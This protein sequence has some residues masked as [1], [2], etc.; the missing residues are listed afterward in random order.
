MIVPKIWCI[1]MCLILVACGGG[2]GSGNDPSKNASFNYVFR[3]INQNTTQFNVITN[4]GVADL[5]GDGLDDVVI[6]GGGNSDGINFITILIQTSEGTLTDRT[7]DLL[8]NNRISGTGH[9]LIADFDRDGY[10]DIWL[11][12][13]DDY[14]AAAASDMFWGSV[15][16]K[17]TRQHVDSG[18]ASHGACLADLN[19]DGYPDMLVY[20]TY[21]QNSWNAGY[22]INNGNRTFSQMISN[23]FVNGASACAVIKDSTTT[24]LAVLQSG[25][26]QMPGYASSINIMDSNLNLIKQIGIPQT[27]TSLAGM[28]TAIPID[29]NSDGLVD[30][31]LAWESWT[32]GGPGR[33]DVWLNQ[34]NDNFA[35]SYTLDRSHNVPGDWISFTY[36]NDLYVFFDAPAADA[37]LYKR[38]NGQL[39]PYKTES[40]F[41]ISTGLGGTAT[42]GN[43]AVASGTIYRGNNGLYVLQKLSSGLYTKKL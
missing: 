23:Q 16:G 19:A 20:G 1:L 34:G 11:P 8:D 25:T 2:G 26:N 37:V 28:V 3:V 29:V 10:Q 43:H 17:F 6:G 5:N 39:V 32:A 15:S 36:Q 13:A 12:G 35:Y 31:I 14:K 4:Y 22:Y 9:V 21:S 38:Q 33:K 41:G 7:L 40:I 24:H 30:F 42:A 27:D 18:L